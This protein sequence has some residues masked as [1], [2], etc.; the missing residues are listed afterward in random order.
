MLSKEVSSTIFK[1]FGMTDHWRTLYPLGQREKIYFSKKHA[2]KLLG[3][4]YNYK[5]A[6]KENAL[7]ENVL[8]DTMAE[9][10]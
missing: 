2:I 9:Q 5:K 6:I 10:L 3:M 4:S 8:Y 7:H 1:V